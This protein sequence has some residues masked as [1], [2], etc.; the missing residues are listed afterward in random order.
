M[1]I[2][3]SG[4][5]M[6]EMLGVLAI[7]GVL[8][9]GGIAGYAKAMS[10]Y[11]INKSIEQVTQITS[12]VRNLF[13]G[14][15]NFSALC[16]KEDKINSA[17][18]QKAHLVP[19]EMV[20]VDANTQAVT[21]NNPFG[22]SVIIGCG[23]KRGGNSGDTDKAFVITYENV[24]REACIELATQDWGVG[25]SSGLIAV[26]VNTAIANATLGNAV[27]GCSQAKSMTV[28]EASTAC[29]STDTG[30][31]TISWKFF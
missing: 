18:I 5:S 29:A 20:E 16:L 13:A 25:A 14:H 9:V 2:N 10:K 8:S 27:A 17:L 24:P 7:I 21:L 23:S 26:C 30:L 6:I 4:R 19:T 12:S 22:G 11:R 1:K 15:K 3:E 31:N 28:M